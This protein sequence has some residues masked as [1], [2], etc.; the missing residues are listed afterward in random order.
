MLLS[1]A[2]LRSSIGRAARDRILSRFT[3]EQSLAT[4][5]DLYREVVERS[6]A[7]PV[8]ED[9]L[10]DRHQESSLSGLAAS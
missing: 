3:L 10:D 6:A 8:T 7:V 4:F 9:E 1:D 5:A 2:K